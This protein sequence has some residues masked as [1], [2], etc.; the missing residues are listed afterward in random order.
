[1]AAVTFEQSPITQQL[2]KVMGVYFL[3]IFTLEA[4]VKLGGLGLEQYF[5]DNW[6]RLDFVIVVLCWVGLLQTTHVMDVCETSQPT[7]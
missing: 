2:W 1:M 4:A 6:N 7:A 5:R 3:A